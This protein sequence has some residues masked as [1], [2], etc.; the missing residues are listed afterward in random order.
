MQT[1]VESE[2]G[3]FIASVAAMLTVRLECY[4]PKQME[5]RIRDLARKHHADDL[6][7]FAAMLR[8]NRDL[9]RE[10]EQHITINI[11]EF[12]RNPEA[13]N[14]LA[15]HILPGLGGRLQA[16]QVWSAGCSNGAEPY[17]LA[18]LL[19][20]Y[21]PGRRHC[22]L[23]TDIDRAML[24]KARKGGGYGDEDIRGLPAAFRQACLVREGGT[25]KVAER[26][27]ATVRFQRHD[28]LR[29]TVGQTFHLIACRNVVIYFT[30]EAKAVLYKKFADALKPEGFL[31]IG[32]TE[33]ISRP[34]DVGLQYVAPCF[35]QKSVR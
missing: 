1:V 15:A 34:A 16:L 8:G 25:Y 9:L 2:Y 27:T 7:S 31:F 4:K 35:Y 5:R 19:E 18:M 12:Y 28:L 3:R 10:F 21:L 6:A 13:F 26:V 29:D 32:A 24:E 11:S 17:T 23:A 33:T 30:D 20:Q 22:I 14:Y